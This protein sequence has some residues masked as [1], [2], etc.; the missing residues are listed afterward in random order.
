MRWTLLA[1]P[2][3]FAAAL[4][5]TSLSAA[6]QSSTS[7]SA[8]KLNPFNAEA[9]V[10]V[11][12]AALN[13]KALAAA[14]R[15]KLN[16]L[17][18]DGLAL[19]PLDARLHA[20]WGIWTEQFQS[21]KEARPHFK[22]A[23]ALLPT[24][25][26][27]LLR[28]LDAALKDRAMERAV[29]IIDVISRR[30]PKFWPDIA[31]A[32]PAILSDQKALDAAV[33]SFS[34]AET[35]FGRARLIKSLLEIDGAE[36][37]AAYL[38]KRWQAMGVTPIWRHANNVTS[39][40]A[41]SGQPRAAYLFFLSMLTDEQQE[42]AGYIFNGTFDYQPSGNMFDWQIRNQ[43]GIS[44]DRLGGSSSDFQPSSTGMRIS[45]LDAPV[46]LRN[47]RQ[48]LQLP[49]AQF[50][51]ELTLSTN[52]LRGPGPIKLALDCLGQR[53]R[54]ATVE[55]PF[56]AEDNTRLVQRLQIPQDNCAAQ[57]IYL[58]NDKFVGSWTNRYVGNVHLHSVR[59]TLVEGQAD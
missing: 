28:A 44:I 43:A 51:L 59:L 48:F 15:E 37:Q 21:P 45:F 42:Q 26:Q 38:I 22:T 46:R 16:V 14:N 57:E 54:V 9:R 41:A 7:L 52:G 17:V 3:V 5:A 35:Q 24:E 31:P 23:L 10:Q 55:I 27:S 33:E 56:R 4:L 13:D 34:Q 19:S 47:L 11:V 49:S 50:D 20:M 25:N 58:Y 32:L 1:F 2:I 29:Q 12:A 36:R 6:L 53:T 39:K 40:L 18:Q 8:V 30:W